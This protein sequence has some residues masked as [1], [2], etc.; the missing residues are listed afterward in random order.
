[1]DRL[2]RGQSNGVQKGLGVNSVLSWAQPLTN[3]G[4]VN[5]RRVRAELNQADRVVLGKSWHENENLIQG[6]G[7]NMTIA[8]QTGMRRANRDRGRRCGDVDAL[9]VSSELWFTTSRIWS[10]FNTTARSVSSV[11]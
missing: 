4:R 1:M 3:W 10:Q 6:F 5:I 9:W 8:D 7:R 11:L 2:Q